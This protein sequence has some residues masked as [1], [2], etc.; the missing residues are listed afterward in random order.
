ML[1]ALAALFIGAIL[2][3]AAAGGAW[4]AHEEGHWGDNPRAPTLANFTP[5][6]EAWALRNG[7]LSPRCLSPSTDSAPGIRRGRNGWMGT[8]VMGLGVLR[9]ALKTPSAND[10]LNRDKT[11]Q[12]FD[13]LAKEGYFGFQET[14][15]E[16]ETGE[17]MPAREYVLT[18]KGWES[19]NHGC[20]HT[21]RREVV[22][23]TSQA[24]IQPD[25]EGL[26]VYEVVYK[27]GLR[28]LPSWVTGPN[29]ADLFGDMKP[30][31]AVEEKRLRLVRADKGWLPEP[32]IRPRVT[33]PIDRARLASTLDELLPVPTVA[34]IALAGK[35]NDFF[36][37]PRACLVV[38]RAK[39]TDADEL[40]WSLNGPVSFTLLDVDA[41]SS[42]QPRIRD[43]WS[44]RLTNLARVGMLREES[45]PRDIQRNR[46][47][48]TRYTLDEKLLPHVSRNGPGCVWI[49]PMKIDILPQGIEQQSSGE[50]LR[51]YRFKAVG[52]L[53]EDAWVRSLPW[54][55]VPEVEAYLEHG[56]PI[57]GMVEFR[58]GAWRMISAGTA[59]AMIIEQPRK[60]ETSPSFVSSG[61]PPGSTSDRL[62]VQPVRNSVHVVAVYKALGGSDSQREG[63]I[64]VAVGARSNPVTLVLSAYDPVH[65]QIEPDAGA[66]IAGVVIMGYHPGRA[67]G[68]PQHLVR[69][70]GGFLQDYRPDGSRRRGGHNP[71]ETAET[72]ERLVGRRPDSIDRAYETHYVSIGSSLVPPPAVVAPPSWQGGNVPMSSGA[73]VTIT[74]EGQ[75]I[76]VHRRRKVM[77]PQSYR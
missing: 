46:P 77:N 41:Y 72:V 6:I 20:F 45:L 69:R 34:T 59:T 31:T 56:V 71:L 25:P 9:I 62:S 12:R 60:A 57:Q 67:S 18:Q 7:D 53:A 65:W 22:E 8:E 68:V 26:R 29:A 70:A 64:R 32:A 76:P 27:V 58:S 16:L 54:S 42:P 39:G 75:D 17:L 44:M 47:S 30:H 3:A 4:W 49:G 10:Q 73:G 33:A 40:E 28:G 48:G 24:R 19:S 2:I 43:S 37:E 35:E 66:S 13:L 1:K 15:L 5:V 23:V 11:V 61:I 74:G 51:L 21:G 36:Q 14:T 50:G 52:R 38:P 63:T 55:G